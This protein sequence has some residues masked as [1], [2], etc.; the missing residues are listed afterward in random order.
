MKTT[1]E[2]PD[3]LMDEIKNLGA[4]ERRKVGEVVADLV[5]AGLDSR[6]HTSS[7]AVG[8]ESPEQWMRQWLALADELMQDTR[9]RS[10]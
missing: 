8:D 4:R 10:G 3:P 6:A 2:L 7:R 5:R 1:I 9:D